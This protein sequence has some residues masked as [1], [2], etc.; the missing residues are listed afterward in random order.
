[1]LFLVLGLAFGSFST[2]LLSRVP[3]DES[4]GGRSHCPFC[5]RILSPLELVPVLSFLWQRG[6]CRGCR[7]VIPLRYPLLE[8]C[9]ACTFIIASWWLEATL[10]ATLGLAISLWSLLIIAILDWNTK[11]IPDLLTAAVAIGAVAVHVPGGGVHALIAASVGLC[12]FGIQWIAGRGRFLGSG[13]VLLAAAIG[14]FL[15]SWQLL[16]VAMFVAYIAGAMVATGILLKTGAA[17]RKMQ[18]PFGPFLVLGAIIA[19]FAG[20]RILDFLLM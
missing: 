8:L 20:E 9:G 18:M 10:A 6:K 1:M 15:G 4:I 14:L 19:F 13:D 2:V 16:I 12:V 3:A 11:L 7:H 5:R 17:A